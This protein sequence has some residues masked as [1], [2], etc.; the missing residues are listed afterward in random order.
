MYERSGL[1]KLNQMVEVI[2]I[3]HG[4]FDIRVNFFIIKYIKRYL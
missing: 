1:F 2:F 4:D 3:I